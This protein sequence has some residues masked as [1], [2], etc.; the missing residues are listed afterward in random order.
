VTV[1]GYSVIRGGKLLDLRA[2]RG[3]AADILVSGGAIAEIGPPGLAA[4][5]E[6]AEIDARDRLLIP[7]LVN[8]HTHAHGGLAKGLVP[9]RVPL[10]V[11]LASSGAITGSRGTE[12][13]YLSALVSAVEMVRKGCTASY[14]LAVEYPQ[15]SV[16][17]M[18]AV[19]QA[20]MDVGMR[21]VVAPMMADRTLYQ[22]L[23]GLLE[24]VP[25]PLRAEAARLSTAPYE[26]SIAVC[27]A[28]LRDWPFDRERIR[29]AVAPT[30]PLHCSDEFMRACH[31]LSR[32]FEVGLQTHLAET[33]SQAVLGLKKYGK[34][35]VAHLAELGLLDARM[36]AAHAIWITPDDIRRLADAGAHVSHN[37][38]SN[39]RL[40]SGVA[41]VR[42]MMEAGLGVGL[43]TDATN[44]ADGNNMFEVTRLAAY[45]S[46]LA[47][48]DHGQWLSVEEAFT[49]ATVGGAGVLGF[50]GKLGRIAIG[51]KAD[52]VFLDLANINYV[53]LG[54]AAVQLVNGET[55]SAVDS[56][57]IDGRMVLENGRLLTI[58]EEKL[59]QDAERAAARIAESSKGLW[60][61]AQAAAQVV[62][63]FCLGQARTPHPVHR[64]LR[65]EDFR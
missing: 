44:T 15:P 57:M 8:G 4:P 33:K 53:P 60:R 25:E 52:I 17:G 37:P 41:P 59:R 13:K 7:G 61:F 14:D 12:D 24:A 3:E 21:A 46:R 2:H 50:G 38:M 39:L 43:G 64:A 30:I 28:I 23:P 6:A 55:G 35:L 58:D 40:G 26:T 65:E 16:E 1:P 51:Y 62:G 19:A 32:E 63:V 5:A 29:P 42:L 36:S 22:A 27:E 9:D 49:M 11:F 31:R 47:T 48:P 10:E 18:R 20:Y 54:D 56:V 34:S 45:L